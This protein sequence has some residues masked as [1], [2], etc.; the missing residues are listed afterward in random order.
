MYRYAP[1]NL[2]YRNMIVCTYLREDQYLFASVRYLFAGSCTLFRYILGA[3][4]LLNHHTPK[5]PTTPSTRRHSY[6]SP[7]SCCTRGTKCT[8]ALLYSIYSSA[9]TYEYNTRYVRVSCNVLYIRLPLGTCH[10]VRFRTISVLGVFRPIRQTTASTVAAESA[11]SQASTAIAGRLN[12]HDSSVRRYILLL[13]Y[14]YCCTST[15][16][17]RVQTSLL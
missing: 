10:W 17:V 7:V 13:L 3:R 6:S 16:S 15:D 14:L 11:Q 1:W 8:R 12:L 5:T 4:I 9:S 2:G